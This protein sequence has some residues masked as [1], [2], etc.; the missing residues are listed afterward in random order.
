MFLDQKDA[1]LEFAKHLQ[2]VLF[3]QKIL[4]VSQKCK[5]ICVVPPN[6]FALFLVSVLYINP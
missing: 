3:A 5:A 6:F 1:N 4:L 2:F